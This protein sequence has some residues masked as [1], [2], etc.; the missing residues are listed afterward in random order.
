MIK[1]TR[2]RQ[3]NIADKEAVNDNNNNNNVTN[4][5]K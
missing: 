2:L 4:A 1:H 3:T 5:T